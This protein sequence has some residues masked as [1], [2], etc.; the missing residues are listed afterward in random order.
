MARHDTPIA[1]PRNRHLQLVET[2]SRVNP[3]HPSVRAVEMFDQDDADAHAADRCILVTMP[4]G[5]RIAALL[6]SVRHHLPSPKAVDEACAILMG[7]RR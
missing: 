3:R 7:K 5:V 6:Q 1:E 2:R 4:E